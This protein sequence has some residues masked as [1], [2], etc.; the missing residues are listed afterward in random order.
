MNAEELPYKIRFAYREEWQD[1]V[2]LAWK[3]FQTFEAPDYSE[4]GI[5]S[6]RNFITDQT[7]YKMFLSGTYQ[8]MVAVCQT[9]I[10]GLISVRDMMHISLLFVDEQYHKRGIGRALIQAMGNYLMQ[11][12]GIVKMTVN[13]SPYAIGFYHTLGFHDLKVKQEEDG[14]SYTPMELFI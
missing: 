2:A 3:T 14:I 10:V 7:L 11:E 4:K 9:K 8:L 5:E 1:I 6:F 13:S 12:E